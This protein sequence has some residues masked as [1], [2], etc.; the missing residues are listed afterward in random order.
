[1]LVSGGHDAQ[2]FAYRIPQFTKVLPTPYVSI[3]NEWKWSL[4]TAKQPHGPDLGDVFGIE[5]LHW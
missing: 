4:G 5:M 3:C 2:L 1:M